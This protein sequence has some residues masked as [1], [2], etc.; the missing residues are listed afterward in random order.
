MPVELQIIRAAEFV[1]LGTQGK[2]DL[3]T[4]REVL[5]QLA[6]ACRKR[7]IDRALL[8]LREV[9]PGPIP[10]LTPTELASLVSTFHEAGFTYDQRLAVLYL[11]DPHHGARLFAFISTLKGWNVKAF[12]DFE[13]AIM[14]L[15]SEQQDRPKVQGG[16]QIVEIQSTKRLP[17]PGSKDRTWRR[18]Q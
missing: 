17:G 9:H 18:R 11:T 8:D 14:W 3:A 13:D 5:V 2:L 1:R 15:S 12:G 7:A 6:R 10:M 16:T 4:S